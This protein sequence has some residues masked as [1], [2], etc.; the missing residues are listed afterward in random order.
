MKILLNALLI[1]GFNLVIADIGIIIY[2]EG[3]RSQ[4]SRGN[5]V[6]LRLAES[7]IRP[8]TYQSLVVLN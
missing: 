7:R 2:P 1:L 4:E 5:T 8:L 6:R 3:V